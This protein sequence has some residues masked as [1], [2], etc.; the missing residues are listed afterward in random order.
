MTDSRI[1]P[2]RNAAVACQKSLER[3]LSFP[4]LRESGWAENRLIDFNLWSKGAGV[5][6]KGKLAL[7]ERLSSKPEV[8]KIVVNLLSLL[9]MFI[10][11]CLEKAR[12]SINEVTHA[13][14]LS[15]EQDGE[16]DEED[17]ATTTELSQ[18]EVEARKD[19]EETLSQIIRLTVAIRKAGSDARLKRADRSFDKQNPDIQELKTSLELFIHPRGIKEEGLNEIQTRLIEANLRRRHRFNYAKLHSKKLARRDTDLQVQSQPSKPVAG[20]PEIESQQPEETPIPRNMDSP[21]E[22]PNTSLQITDIMPLAPALTVTTAAS[23]IEGTLIITEHK[24]VSPPRPA[25]TVISRI[26]SGITYPRPPPVSRFSSVFRCP[27]C[28]QS[29][30]IS[31]LE[32]TQWKKHLASDI[33][34]YTCVF[35]GCL[36]PLQLYLTRNDWETHIKTDHGQIWNCVICDQLGELTSHEFHQEKDITEH[37]EIKHKGDV[38]AD[39]IAMFVSASCSPRPTE[40]AGCPICPGI[41]EG[42]DMIEH[43]ARCVHDFSLRSLPAP[44][45]SD[46]PEDYFDVNS[47]NDSSSSIT[48]SSGDAMRDLEGLPPLE[49]N[50]DQSADTRQTQL[51]ESSLQA[52]KQSTLQNPSVRLQAWLLDCNDTYTEDPDEGSLDTKE[53]PSGTSIKIYTI[54]WVCTLHEEFE[55]ALAVLDEIGAFSTPYFEGD[56]RYAVGLIG[57]HNVVVAQLG[58]FLDSALHAFGTPG[59]PIGRMLKSFP[60]VKALLF[61]G[62]AGGIPPISKLDTKYTLT[63]TQTHPDIRLGDVVVSRSMGGYPAVAEIRIESEGQVESYTDVSNNIPIALD[64]FVRPGAVEE[65]IKL[66]SETAAGRSYR[67]RPLGILFRPDYR[68]TSTET[69]C[70]WCD[71]SMAIREQ[72]PKEVDF[73]LQINYGMIFTSEQTPKPPLRDEINRIFG[74]NALCIGERQA[75]LLQNVPHIDIRG[76]SNYLDSH[77]Y[78]P[79]K[80]HAAIAAAAYAKLLLQRLSHDELGEYTVKELINVNSE[81]YNPRITRKKMQNAGVNDRDLEGLKQWSPRDHNLIHAQHMEEVIPINIEWFRSSRAFSEWRENRGKIFHFTGKPGSG[82]TYMVSALIDHLKEWASRISDKSF[83]VAFVY[84]DLDQKE[85]QTVTNLFANLLKQLLAQQQAPVP[86]EIMNIQDWISMDRVKAKDLIMRGLTLAAAEC[87]RIFILIDALD[88]SDY[89]TRMYQ[90]FYSDILEFQLDTGANFFLTSRFSPDI[91]IEDLGLQKALAGRLITQELRASDLQIE[92]YIRPRLPR[93]L[94]I[95]DYMSSEHDVDPITQIAQRITEQAQGNYALTNAQLKLIS[96]ADTT[97]QAI[98]LLRPRQNGEREYDSFFKGIMSRLVS[99][100]DKYKIYGVV[101]LTWLL[102]SKRPLTKTELR[103]AVK[104][105][106]NNSEP[107]SISEIVTSC[108]GLID[109]KGRHFV[110]FHPSAEEYV[111]RTQDYWLRSD[112]LPDHRSHVAHTLLKYLC[113]GVESSTDVRKQ[114]T[115]LEMW[116]ERVRREKLELEEMRERR[117]REEEKEDQ[118]ELEIDA[119]VGEQLTLLERERERVRR[120]KLELEELEVRLRR[121]EEKENQKKFE[122]MQ[123]DL[124]LLQRQLEED[125][126]EKETLK[127]AAAKEKEILKNQADGLAR[128]TEELR[129]LQVGECQCPEDFRRRLMTYPLYNYAARFWGYH[130]RESGIEGTSDEVIHFLRDKDLVSAA[131]QALLERRPLHPKFTDRRITGMHLASYF[132]LTISLQ[133]L[134][135]ESPSVDL[136]DSDGR[137]PLSWAARYGQKEAVEVLL[138]A[139]ADPDWK[140]I[141]WMTALSWA[142]MGGYGEIVY[143][144]LSNPYGPVARLDTSGPKNA[145]PLQLAIELGRESIAIIILKYRTDLVH[146]YHGS[147]PLHFAAHH[148]RKQVVDALLELGA[149]P[150]SRNDSGNL[151]LVLAAESGHV[152][153]VESLLPYTSGPGFNSTNN[154]GHSA[155]SIARLKGHTEVVSI[156]NKHRI[157]KQKSAATISDGPPPA[158]DPKNPDPKS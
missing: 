140:D 119:D 116:R 54:G 38:D 18:L 158:L 49:F 43:I 42:Q 136:K 26:T 125:R 128:Q 35:A 89:C 66:T 74:C 143:L 64:K 55:A 70:D 58:V 105:H 37:L 46:R 145:N 61:V 102:D 118:R 110:F 93:M 33:V 71:R 81:T 13:A 139:G 92:Y 122:R 77:Y 151:P 57:D 36:Q 114:L 106:L 109:A 44:S 95:F 107:P 11:N 68:H 137:T 120:E 101:S 78:E 41:D 124:A 131:A 19:V 2:V 96:R 134:I 155:L 98:T 22:A 14:N 104:A 152:S 149:D 69:T 144:L 76:I 146:G 113:M 130:V 133:S 50:S 154:L 73:N 72:P 1:G 82:K 142:V 147:T 31:F 28:C 20:A 80:R 121:E 25:A 8:Q 97:V 100:E 24:T 135:S 3:C 34:P 103:E 65:C 12:E 27:C 156:L 108:C 47:E 29:L 150:E 4:R 5:F 9:N 157:Q 39:E 56:N 90:S 32:R 127:R 16:R 153:T 67:W 48:S 45:D 53:S 6:A 88:E 126:Q 23:A 91:I 138:Q 117:R 52:I 79:W 15:T 141:D 123:K 83:R 85:G 17:E 59:W 129:T 10:E 60:S 62:I 94:K 99:Q 132:G 40:A 21:E 7:D 115:L 86:D 63:P 84:C 51:T 111:R 148:G 30:P 112:W 75:G 87:S